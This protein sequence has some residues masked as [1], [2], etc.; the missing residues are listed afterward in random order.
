MHLRYSD[1]L[2]CVSLRWRPMG[3]AARPVV[4]SL[5]SHAYVLESSRMERTR[6]F[7]SIAHHLPP[8][9][10]S[11]AYSCCPAVCV[12]PDFALKLLLPLLLSAS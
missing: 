12:F 1:V 5:S 6:F 3:T 4:F 10:P 9:C 2:L 11:V 7:S 8:Y